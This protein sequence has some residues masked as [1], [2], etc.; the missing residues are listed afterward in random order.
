MTVYTDPDA[1]NEW[2]IKEYLEL[3]RNLRQMAP[4][5]DSHFLLTVTPR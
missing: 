4:G 2:L 5:C 3:A 1:M